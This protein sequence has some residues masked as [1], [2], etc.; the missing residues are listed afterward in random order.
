MASAHPTLKPRLC[1][2]LALCGVYSI[3]HI[4]SGAEYIGGS[5]RIGRRWM[6]HRAMLRHGAHPVAALQAIWALI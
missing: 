2:P 4:P 3:M 1:T 6:D 5:T